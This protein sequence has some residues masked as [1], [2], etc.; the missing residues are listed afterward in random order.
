MTDT[1]KT[2]D[3]RVK[4]ERSMLSMMPETDLTRA[5]AGL[6]YSDSQT[7][8]AWIFYRMGWNARAAQEGE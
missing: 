3:E 7:D 4:F 1:V 8:L 6:N 2:E 5:N